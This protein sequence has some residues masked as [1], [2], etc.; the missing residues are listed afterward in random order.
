MP[1][2]PKCWVLFFFKGSFQ[3][4]LFKGSRKEGWEKGREEGRKK[5]KNERGIESVRCGKKEEENG[6]GISEERRKER[7]RSNRKAPINMGGGK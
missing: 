7:E 5:I 6:G 2:P 3:R 1:L 4:I